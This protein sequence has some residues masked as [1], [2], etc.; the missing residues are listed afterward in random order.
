MIIRTFEQQ[1]LLKNIPQ[2]KVD[3]NRGNGIGKYFLNGG[4]NLNFFHGYSLKCCSNQI[5]FFV[6]T[7]CA[8]FSALSLISVPCRANQKKACREP[9]SLFDFINNN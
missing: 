1:G 4:F 8:S 3:T 7:F 9:A 5:C 2:S 6:L